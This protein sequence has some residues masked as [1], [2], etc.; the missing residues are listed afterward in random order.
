[1]VAVDLSPRWQETRMA[2][3]AERRLKLANNHAS[4]RDAGPRRALRPWDK[5]HGYR[6]SS[7][8]EARANP[9]S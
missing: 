3:V 4:L 5:S 9:E 2:G 1:M 6:R 8:R 7:L